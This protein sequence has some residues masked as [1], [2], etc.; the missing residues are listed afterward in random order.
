MSY[1]KGLK[2]F[3][4]VPLEGMKSKVDEVIA[5]A[6]LTTYE[7]H[8]VRTLAKPDKNEWKVGLKKY[9]D[10]FTHVPPESVLDLFQKE[11]DKVRK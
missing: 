1:E 4:G 5:L 10:R 7:C 3:Q 6:E 9:S 11:V 8:L 2:E